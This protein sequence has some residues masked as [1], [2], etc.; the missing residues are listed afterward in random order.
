M[1]DEEG[2]R[3]LL[4]TAILIQTKFIGGIIRVIKSVASK[5]DHLW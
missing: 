3:I 2:K 1:F 5:L 4:P